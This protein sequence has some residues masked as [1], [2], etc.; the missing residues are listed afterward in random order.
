M[1]GIFAETVAGIV[2]VDPRELQTRPARL[3][4]DGRTVGPVLTTDLVAILDL[5]ALASDPRITVNEEIG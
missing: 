4:G 5:E 2:S 1:F 3:T